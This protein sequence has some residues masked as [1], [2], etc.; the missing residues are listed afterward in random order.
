VLKQAAGSY[1]FVVGHY[2]VFPQAHRARFEDIALSENFVVLDRILHINALIRAY[3]PGRD[4]YQYD[5][6]WGLHS[7]GPNGE[8]ADN[9]DR[10]AN[11]FGT[12]HR[13]VRLIY[14]VREG[15]LR[16][17]CGWQ[18]LSHPSGQGFGIL[19]Q[20]APDKQYMLYWLYYYFNRHVGEWVLDVQGS[21][22]Y[23]TATP[24]TYPEG[25]T[26]PITPAVATVSEDGATVYLIIANGS[27]ERAVPCR[28][29]FRS[30]EP[31]T[32]AAVLL[33]HSDPDGK[34]LLE[35]KEDAVSELPLTLAGPLLTCTIPP[36]SVVFV[37][38]SRQP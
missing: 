25:I 30:F 16:G 6:E 27:W 33:S 2:Y 36:H 37:R 9:V 23:Y 14:Y 22:P 17:A 12:L 3:N 11:I 13:A 20:D 32:A 8:R 26:G 18:M 19:S 10:N 34:P 35:R 15:M 4:V 7:F 1:D 31:A 24:G 38:V 5:T 28:T 21:A 29:T